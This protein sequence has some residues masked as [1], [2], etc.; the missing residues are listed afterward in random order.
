MSNNVRAG[1]GIYRGC[2]LSINE[3]AL[4]T[5][6]LAAEVKT[7]RKNFAAEKP[8]GVK[9]AAEQAARIAGQIEALSTSLA[10]TFAHHVSRRPRP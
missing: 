3:I 9:L 4:A 10:R 5:R 7:M 1:R 8:I 6:V 2:I